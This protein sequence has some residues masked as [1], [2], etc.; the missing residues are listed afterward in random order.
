MVSEGEGFGLPLVE[1]AQHGLALI[2][3]DLPVFR[4]LAGEH[5]FYWQGSGEPLDATI[6]A[7]IGLHAL[8]L[9]P[10]PQG[11][12][13]LGWEDSTRALLAAVLGAGAELGPPDLRHAP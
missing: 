4:E 8:G 7:W 11:L 5:A 10:R 6:E 3:R 1:A 9:H 2:A 13:W 12:A